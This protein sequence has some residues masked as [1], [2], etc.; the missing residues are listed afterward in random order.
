VRKRGDRE[1]RGSSNP[2][3]G[4]TKT[5]PGV[6]AEIPLV[7]KGDFYYKNL[8]RFESDLKGGTLQRRSQRVTHKGRK[9]GTSINNQR[10][11]S[12]LQKREPRTGFNKIALSQKGEKKDYENKAKRG[13]PFRV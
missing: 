10:G 8:R 7:Q 1:G 2:V 13:D 11:L 9:W 5:E 6:R 4:P 12:R 3:S